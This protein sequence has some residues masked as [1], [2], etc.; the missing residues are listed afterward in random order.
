MGEFLS[1]PNKEK[2]SDEG[3]NSQLKFAS[4]GM[5]GWRK[6]MEDSHIT[7]LCVGGT[8]CNVF[9]VFDG[10][11]GREVAQW[12]KKKFTD[13]L[14]KN[15]NFNSQNYG[16]A[17]TENF[18]RMDVLMVDNQG[19]QELKE[20]SRKSKLDDEKSS[21]NQEKNKNEMFRSLFDPKAQDDCDVAMFTGCTATVCLFDDKKAY[22]ANAGDSRIII[23]KGGVAYSMTVDHKPESD[24][25]R[26]RIYKAEGWV[27]E[28]R[29]KGNLN[30]SR[31]L[32]DLEFKQNKKISPEEQMITANPEITSCEL[33]DL[34]F[35][36]LGCDGVYDCLTNQEVVDFIN[37]RLKKNPNIKLTKILEEMLDQI[38]APDIYTETG[39]GCDN[40][41]S[42]LIQFKKKK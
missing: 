34:D 5:Q 15:K 11:G 7:D 33:K 20:E 31:S 10:H 9:G 29:V 23:S 8:N 27:S 24:E 36:F 18:M 25:E 17:L 39:V 12:V 42:V 28:G 2:I 19:K 40:M 41:S 16:K 3:E 30:L 4:C 21:K 35:I 6:R 38:I 32:G 1:V 14:I 37:S 26:I 22:F 13:E